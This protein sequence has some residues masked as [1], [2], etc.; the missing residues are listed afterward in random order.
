MIIM[1]GEIQAIIIKVMEVVGGIIIQVIS[2]NPKDGIRMLTCMVVMV[3]II[4]IQM[5]GGTQI[6]T[7]ILKG[8]GVSTLINN[9][10]NNSHL[11]HGARIIIT[12]KIIVTIPTKI[13]YLH[14]ILI[15]ITQ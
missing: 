8:G 5:V 2:N 14:K 13:T 10:L 9:H 3:I 7:L 11:H 12:H 4:I 1:D 6:I 15:T